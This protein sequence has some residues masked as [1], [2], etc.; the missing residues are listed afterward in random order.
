MIQENKRSVPSGYLMLVVLAVAQI[1]FAY[2]LVKSAVVISPGGI[3]GFAIAS[4]VIAIF[5]GRLF[6]GPSK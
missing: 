6:H 3:I 2:G 1:A 5:L 4:I